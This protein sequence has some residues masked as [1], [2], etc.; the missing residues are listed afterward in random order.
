ML[1]IF[2]T[3]QRDV[4]L[5]GQYQLGDDGRHAVEMARP[6]RAFPPVGDSGDSNFGGE[7]V[8]IDVCHRRQPQQVAAAF[9]QHRRILRFLPGI[10]AKILM[11]GE[12]RRVDEDRCRHPLG[13]LLPFGHQR[14][15]PGVERAHGR[16]QRQPLAAAS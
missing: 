10:A 16:N 4:R 5:N 11:G 2:L 14:Q 8:R 6:G 7:A 1:E 12:L 3:E 9:L 13:V 15:M